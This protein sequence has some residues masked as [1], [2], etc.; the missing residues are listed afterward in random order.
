M[1]SLSGTPPSYS[2][3]CRPVC[4]RGEF[5][6]ENT[7]L[8]QLTEG[9]QQS[10]RSEIRDFWWLLDTHTWCGLGGNAPVAGTQLPGYPPFKKE[11]NIT[12]KLSEISRVCE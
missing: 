2:N 7:F 1:N 6:R 9:T 3:N 4:L 5:Q 8:E 11:K 10:G 12:G